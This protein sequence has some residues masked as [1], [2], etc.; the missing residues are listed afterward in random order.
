MI[1]NAVPVNFAYALAMQIKK[2]LNG[3]LSNDASYVLQ[4]GELKL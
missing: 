1:G 4:Q 2:Q 3:E